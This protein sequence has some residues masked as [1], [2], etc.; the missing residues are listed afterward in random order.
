VG[1]L[2]LEDALNL[3]CSGV[4]LRGSGLCWDIRK[5]APYETY[6][7]M[8][9]D[10]PIGYNV[11]CFDRYLIRMNEMRQRCKNYATSH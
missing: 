6:A 5:S 11:D 2:N 10:I 7:Q 8:D 3:G 1:V 9:F 4:M